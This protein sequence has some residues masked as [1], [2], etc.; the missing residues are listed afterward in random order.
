MRSTPI[1]RKVIRSGLDGY[2]GAGVALGKSKAHGGRDEYAS[3]VGVG[4][5]VGV[6]DGV[7]AVEVAEGDPPARELSLS[8]LLL[9]IATPVR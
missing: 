1:S 8:M 5:G 2:V 3:G 9:L 7:G 4:V 6:G